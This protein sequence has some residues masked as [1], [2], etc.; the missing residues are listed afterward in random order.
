M[1]ITALRQRHL[2]AYTRKKEHR[3][4][5]YLMWSEAERDESLLLV[6]VH[7]NKD[8]KLLYIQAFFDRGTLPLDK[9]HLW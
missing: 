2:M 1:I 5:A 8:N 6:P 7:C 4:G 9:Q 3:H